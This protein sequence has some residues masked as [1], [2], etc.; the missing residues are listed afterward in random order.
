[1]CIG[2]VDNRDNIPVITLYHIDKAIDLVPWHGKVNIVIPRDK[3]LMTN[4]AQQRSKDHPVLKG[5][6]LAQRIELAEQLGAS[7][8]EQPHSTR[9]SRKGA[10]EAL[11]GI[12]KGLTIPT[13][14]LPGK[15]HH[16]LVVRLELV[17]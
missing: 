6:L 3:T 15:H 11:L 12:I 14:A 1:M 10:E 17:T 7:Q 2:I 8:L 9:S 13:V 16:L 4:R 5:M